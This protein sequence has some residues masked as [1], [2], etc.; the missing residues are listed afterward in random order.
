MPEF[1]TNLTISATPSDMKHA[2]R[3]QDL[4]DLIGAKM[5]D[6][7]VAATTTDLAADYDTAAKTLTLKSTET[8]AAF[9]ADGISLAQGDRVLVAAQT[10]DT[11]NGIYT[12][13]AVGTDS[14]AW[15]LTRAT[16]FDQTSDIFT[17]VKVHVIKGDS[18]KDATFVLTTDS[19]AIGGSLNF[20]QDSGKVEGVRQKVFTIGA[21]A[22]DT[23]WT[24]THGFNTYDVTVDIVEQSSGNGYP[25]VYADVTRPSLNSVRIDF[26]A[27]IGATGPDYKVIVRA[28]P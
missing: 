10:D 20:S 28:Q 22:S 1:K 24:F 25:T 16:D 9:K 26:A 14:V 5:K 17:G 12:V 19:P 15:V 11:E 4:Y 21:H 8:K 23:N 13:T 6:P 2:A 27:A 18:F 3:L 7:V